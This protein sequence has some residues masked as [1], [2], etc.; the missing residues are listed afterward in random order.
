MLQPS[1]WAVLAKL[2][3]FIRPRG[4][5]LA[6][7]RDRGDLQ[8]PAPP[9]LIGETSGLSDRDVGQLAATPERTGRQ[10]MNDEVFG[11]LKTVDGVYGHMFS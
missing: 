11:R 7:V 3:S 4:K 6:D 8:D 10:S 1:E 9:I 5:E 2:V